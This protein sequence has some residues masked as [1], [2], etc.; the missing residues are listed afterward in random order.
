MKGLGRAL[1]LKS[2]PLLPFCFG[3]W[4]RRAGKGGEGATKEIG[5]FNLKVVLRATTRTSE[6][7]ADPEP[8]L[9][10]QGLSLC[11]RIIS[12]GPITNAMSPV[13]PFLPTRDIS[14]PGA[15]PALRSPEQ[16][17]LPLQ[18][19]SSLQRAACF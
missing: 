15:P 6:P 10:P 9:Q 3:E 12:L 16:P 4:W 17:H 19:D 18:L 11:Q 5:V 2:S 8:C 1:W 13:K 14:F 7:K